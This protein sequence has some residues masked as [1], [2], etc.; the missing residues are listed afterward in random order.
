[1]ATAQALTATSGSVYSAGSHLVAGFS[2]I[3]DATSYLIAAYGA[4]INSVFA[5]SA[6]I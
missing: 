5:H 6:M 4:W 1:M 3:A 2:F